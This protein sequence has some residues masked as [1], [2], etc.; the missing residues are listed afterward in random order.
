MPRWRPAEPELRLIELSTVGLAGT[1][2]EVANVGALL[3]GPDGGFTTENA[4]LTHGAA[5]YWFDNLAPR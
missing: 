5:S 2:D 1:P 4:V 3:M